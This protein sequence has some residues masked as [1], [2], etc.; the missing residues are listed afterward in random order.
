MPEVTLKL[1]KT[2]VFTP[3][4]SESNSAGFVAESLFYVGSPSNVERIAAP[5]TS[6]PTGSI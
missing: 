2:F 1:Q 5:P 3:L 6:M 4:N